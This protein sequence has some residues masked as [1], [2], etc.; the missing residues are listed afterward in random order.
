MISF[1]KYVDPSGMLSHHLGN[2][3]AHCINND[4]AYLCVK[5]NQYVKKD[6][7]GFRVGDIVEMG[8]ALIAF[9]QASR[10]EDNKQIGKLVLRT[11]T[12]LDNSFAKAAFKARS[13]NEA[14]APSVGSRPMQV[15]RSLVKK[16]FDLHRL[17]SDDE[18]YSETRRRMAA[19][20]VGKRHTDM[21]TNG[22]QST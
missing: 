17:S 20:R 19:M 2:K 11:L 6:P 8:F 16:C 18:D 15:V 12:L 21:E 7:V 10:K 5:V 13:T 9:R 3:V 22:S 14:K 1:E 4:I